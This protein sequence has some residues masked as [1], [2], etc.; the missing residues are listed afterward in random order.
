[1]S[2][3][4]L[5]EALRQQLLTRA[6]RFDFTQAVRLIHH[7]ARTKAPVG[8]LGPLDNEPLRFRH[9][10]SLSFHSSD[11]TGITELPGADGKLRFALTTT[12]LGLTGATAPLSTFYSEDVLLNDP[13]GSLRAF[14]DL[15]HHRLLSLFYRTRIKYRFTDSFR[16]GGRDPFTRR[17]MAFVGVDADGA[18]SSL[19]LPPYTLLSLAPLLAL[20]SRSARSLRLVLQR[21][22]PTLRVAV[23]SFIARRVALLEDERTRLGRVRTTLDEDF[24]IGAGVIDRSGR[25]RILIGPVSYEQYEQLIPGGRAFPALR[26]VVNQFT[27]GLLEPELQLELDKDSRPAFRLGV[28]RNALLGMNTQMHKPGHENVRMRFVL[29]DDKELSRPTL[30]TSSSLA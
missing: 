4:A 5:R 2:D 9:D 18:V 27:R 21:L 15:F 10:P 14:Y 25:F 22:F 1:V 29:T 13:S 23:E 6:Q 8:E 12:F 26:G 17:A 28:R 3:D 24:V 16:T 30:V 11:V 7:F 20:P 19:G